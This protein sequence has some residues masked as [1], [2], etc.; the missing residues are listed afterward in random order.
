[1]RVVFYVWAFAKVCAEVMAATADVRSRSPSRLPGQEQPKAA[2][3]GAKAKA[4]APALA[5]PREEAPPPILSGSLEEA[6]QLGAWARAQTQEGAG[7]AASSAAT[8]SAGTEQPATPIQ[9]PNALEQS[10]MEHIARLDAGVASLH[11]RTEL[12]AQQIVVATEAATWSRTVLQGMQS[13]Q[14]TRSSKIIYPPG[15]PSEKAIQ[16]I[17]RYCDYWA[18][19]LMGVDTMPPMASGSVALQVTFRSMTARIRAQECLAANPI[20]YSGHTLSLTR[21]TPGHLV[22]GDKPIKAAVRTLESMLQLEEGE[23]CVSLKEQVVAWSKADDSGLLFLARTVWLSST[24]VSIEVANSINPEHFR[25]QFMQRWQTGNNPEGQAQN[26]DESTGLGTQG[27]KGGASKPQGGHRARYDMKQY[28]SIQV[29]HVV[30]SIRE[31]IQEALYGGAILAR[32]RLLGGG[33]AAKA[34][35]APAAS[36][37]TASAPPTQPAAAATAAA[38]SSTG[39]PATTPSATAAAVPA[40]PAST[41]AAQR[42]QVQAQRTSRGQTQ[43]LRQNRYFTEEDAYDIAVPENENEENYVEGWEDSQYTYMQ[44]VPEEYSEAP[45]AAK[46]AGKGMGA[47]ARKGKGKGKENGK[48]KGKDKDKGQNQS[49]NAKGKGKQQKGKGK[50]KGKGKDKLSKGLQALQELLAWQGAWGV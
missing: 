31:E 32:N 1:M 43:L 39:T 14:S 44:D 38:A 16:N 41:V 37:A 9:F 50:G 12:H 29:Q 5:P 48:V 40:A 30:E 20:R 36:E 28:I 15:T 26:M 4:P 7:G 33:T 24:Q 10:L 42:P 8:A 47:A 3:V 23:L 2:G 17:E 34:K 13:R 18:L 22:D 45:A 27:T 6:T 46:A 19:P 49:A 25:E 11:E 35:A 21:C